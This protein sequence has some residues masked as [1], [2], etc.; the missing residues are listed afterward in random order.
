MHF[1]VW[2]GWALGYTVLIFSTLALLCTF[3]HFPILIA[4]VWAKDVLYK[5]WWSSISWKQI[6]ALMLCLSMLIQVVFISIWIQSC[7]KNDD[8]Y[9]EMDQEFQ[10]LWLSMYL[11][12]YF[13][14]SGTYCSES[15]FSWRFTLFY[16]L[17]VLYCYFWMVSWLLFLL[18][19][20]CNNA[21]CKA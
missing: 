20:S 12:W 1:K 19:S 18:R 21:S 6:N 9:C 8:L 14:Y 17:L 5:V 7:L 15:L 2:G 4:M 16:F 3:F 10:S 13:L 11:Q